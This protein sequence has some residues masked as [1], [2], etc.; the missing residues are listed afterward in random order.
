MRKQFNP[1]PKHLTLTNVKANPEIQ[2]LSQ[3]PTCKQSQWWYPHSTVTHHG[4]PYT[5]KHER[6]N[7]CVSEITL[8][9]FKRPNM[10]IL[11]LLIVWI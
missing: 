9:T 11:C 8:T 5:I 10:L 6:G 2:S 7:V 4:N 1:E 3:K